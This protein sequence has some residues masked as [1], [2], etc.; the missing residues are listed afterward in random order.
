MTSDRRCGVMMSRVSMLKQVVFVHCI[1]NFASPAARDSALRVIGKKGIVFYEPG[2]KHNILVIRVDN[3]GNLRHSKPCCMCV[4]FMK[5]FGVYRV[6]YSNEDG[7]ICYQKVSEMEP[8]HYSKG[9]T[10]MIDRIY[11][12]GN[13]AYPKLP[14]SVKTKRL[15]RP[16]KTRDRSD[17]PVKSK[18]SLET[19]ENN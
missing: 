4:Y 3:D 9:L 10:D 7:D 14:V 8:E 17:S 11:F 1:T 6:Y 13:G 12:E 16:Q 19:L 5:M 2:R 15:L 18:K